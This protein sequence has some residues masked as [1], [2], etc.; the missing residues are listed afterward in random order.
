MQKKEAQEEP[1]DQ[2]PEALQIQ[3]TTH[4]R[5]QIVA[6]HP[7]QDLVQRH[8]KELA[9]SSRA[10]CKTNR[11]KPSVRF[12]IKGRFQTKLEILEAQRDQLLKCY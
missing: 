12:Q 2:T 10:D 3:N 7:Q 11:W 6:P 8:R 5:H 4:Y 9:V 1:Q